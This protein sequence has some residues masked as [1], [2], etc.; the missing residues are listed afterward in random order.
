M[1]TQA[2]EKA[3]SSGS[4]QSAP[5][6]NGFLADRIDVAQELMR[7]LD[8]CDRKM[9]LSVTKTTA[10]SALSR[11]L[12]RQARLRVP[13]RKE[14]HVFAKA[15]AILQPSEC[16]RV[17]FSVTPRHEILPVVVGLSSSDGRNAALLPQCVS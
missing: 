13:E 7:F 11:R 10:T 17:V 2:T 8:F 6:L 1:R 15:N 4:E 9:V 3:P 14:L 5:N 16:E 12:F